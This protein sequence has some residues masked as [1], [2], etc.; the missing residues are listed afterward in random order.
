MPVEAAFTL[1][2]PPYDVVEAPTWR[3]EVLTESAAILLW[4]ADTYAPGDLYG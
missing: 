3:G 4:L 2:G 1:L